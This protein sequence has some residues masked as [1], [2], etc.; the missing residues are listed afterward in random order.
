MAEVCG[1]HRRFRITIRVSLIERATISAAAERCGVSLS[2]YA[3]RVLVDAKPSRAA[4]RPA[5]EASLLV[6]V[7]DR[8]GCV[9]SDLRRITCALQA[10]SS[11]VMPGTERDLARSLTELRNLRPV[12]LR[13]LGRRAT[14]A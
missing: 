12:L 9:A 14:G 11:A 4:R 5:V 6:S 1:Q 10:C 8:L 3:R 13:A 7:L 2:A